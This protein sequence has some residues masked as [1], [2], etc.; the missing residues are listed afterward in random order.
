MDAL[1]TYYKN[2]LLADL[3]TEYK[4]RWRA[5]HNDKE[6]LLCLSLCQQSIPHVATFAYAGKGVTKEYV[7]V[8]FKDYING[9][10]VWD[11][12]GVK[13]YSY[14]L[15][16]GKTDAM[17]DKD[18]C[19]LMWFDGDVNVPQTRCTTLYVS[20][21][22]HVRLVC[23]GFSSVRVYLFDESTVTL[24]DVDDETSVIIYRYGRRAN[25]EIGKYC[26]SDKVRIFDKELRL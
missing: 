18:V 14:G 13:G 8:N 20:N 10:T 22:S 7:M 4:G 17:A 15:F 19:S 6:R 24:D 5:A 12:D 16:V 11:A 26:L 21:K 23:D 9:Y 2:A 1:D 3:C 25:V